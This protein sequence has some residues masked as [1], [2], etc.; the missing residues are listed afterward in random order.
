[1]RIFL[2]FFVL[3]KLEKSQFYAVSQAFVR[4]NM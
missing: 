1:M 2:L 4:E 3:E